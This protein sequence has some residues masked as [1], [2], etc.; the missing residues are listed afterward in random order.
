MATATS[1]HDM[2]IADYK[3]ETL[4]SDLGDRMY[5]LVT[6]E[7]GSKRRFLEVPVG[8]VHL[9]RRNLVG[10]TFASAHRQ[11]ICWLEAADMGDHRIVGIE[12]IGPIDGWKDMFDKP[13]GNWEVVARMSDGSV[14]RVFAFYNDE[15]S[16]TEHEFLDLSIKQA[17][18]LKS[19]KDRSY[20]SDGYHQPES[21]EVHYCIACGPG[22]RH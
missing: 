16:F 17:D 19:Q 20:V 9:E 2:K 6:L 12:K 21:R 7:D 3:V 18:E 11:A 1:H 8:R 4:G 14:Q 22:P 10:R 5:V 15:L 13:N